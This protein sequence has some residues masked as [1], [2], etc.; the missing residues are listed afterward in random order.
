M[1][2]R[3]LI[4]AAAAL[5]AGLTSLQALAQASSYPDQPIKWV[6]PYPAGGGTD[7]LARA[8]ADAM[9]VGLGQPIV[10]DNRPG[11]GGVVGTSVVAKAPADGYTIG[12]GA[13]STLIATPLTNPHSTV[14]VPKE[15]VFVS[16]LDS[17]PMFLMVTP[18]VP[19]QHLEGRTRS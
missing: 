11:A 9:R 1:Q 18:T 4:A 17:A 8:L 16:L 6:V 7:T 14:D 15:L 10:I 12:V 19:A 2:R 5:A 3:H 13:N